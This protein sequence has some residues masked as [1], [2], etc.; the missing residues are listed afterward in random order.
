MSLDSDYRQTIEQVENTINDLTQSDIDPESAEKK[1][2]EA[3]KRLKRL[4]QQVDREAGQGTT[5]AGSD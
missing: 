2:N 3:K 4:K 5:T 1:Y